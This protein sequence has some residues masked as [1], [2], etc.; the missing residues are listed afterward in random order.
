MLSLSL[1]PSRWQEQAENEKGSPYEEPFKS[2][3]ASINTDAIANEQLY[4]CSLKSSEIWLR[5]A[6]SISSVKSP[7]VGIRKVGNP[8]SDIFL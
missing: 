1:F 6:L 4:A 8:S 7:M 3:K 5:Y 2:L